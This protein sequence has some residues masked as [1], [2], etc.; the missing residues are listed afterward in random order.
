MIYEGSRYAKGYIM[1][2]GEDYYLAPEPMSYETQKTDLVYQ[3]KDG[4]RLD[5]LAKKF[6]DNASYKWLILQANPQYF[7]EL[8]IKNGDI[9]IIP[10]PKEVEIYVNAS[11]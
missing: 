8:D 10:N 1:K 5:L 7:S 11:I 9:I 4:D 2:D 3:F 6:Y